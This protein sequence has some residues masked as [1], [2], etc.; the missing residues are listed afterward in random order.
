MTVGVSAVWSCVSSSTPRTFA[1]VSLD[2]V[3]GLAVARVLGL[4]LI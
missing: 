2:R 3:D 1:W 4:E